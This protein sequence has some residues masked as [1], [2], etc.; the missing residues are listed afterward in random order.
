M[1]WLL[2]AGP[3]R[4]GDVDADAV[5]AAGKAPQAAQS[6]LAPANARPQSPAAA[7]PSAQ[8]AV[9]MADLQARDQRR[10]QAVAQLQPRLMANLDRCL[11]A[12]AGPRSN[13]RLVL[14]FERTTPTDGQEHFKIAEFMPVGPPAAVDALR[15]TP[16]W[17]CLQSLVGQPLDIPVGPG[18]QEP[19]FQ[20]VVAIPVPDRAGWTPPLAMR[21]SQP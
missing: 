7:Q 2:W 16:V 18:G 3:A 11:A 14:H 15:Q 4:P 19:K 17:S 20:E 8:G 6:A 10:R 9:P 13:Q 21:G 1:V 12:P 5:A